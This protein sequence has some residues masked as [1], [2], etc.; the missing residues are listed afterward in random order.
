MI[1]RYHGTE[2]LITGYTSSTVI[3]G[4]LLADVSIELDDDPF[5]TTQGSGTVEVTMV[6]H[7][8]TNGAS[9]TISGAEDIFDTDGGG[10]APG[11]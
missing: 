5:K 8:F 11:N 9:I 6:A 3:T 1:V 7:G 2:I 10:L 4:T